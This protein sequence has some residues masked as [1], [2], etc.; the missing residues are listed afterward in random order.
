MLGILISVISLAGCS[1]YDDIPLSP[2]LIIG[3]W[4]GVSSSGWEKVDGK[5][6]DK[7]N[8]KESF[9]FDFIEFKFD[10]TGEWWDADSNRKHSFAWCL[11]EHG[12]GYDVEI[13]EEYVGLGTGDI[14][15]IKK[16][17]KDKLILVS[18]DDDP[19]DGWYQED[20]YKRID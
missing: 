13:G 2:A 11:N 14:Y 5:V 4:Q 6:V 17:T 16:V 19:D 1:K 9:D 3:T 7:W 8:D 12:E 20:T 10:A 18:G 15:I